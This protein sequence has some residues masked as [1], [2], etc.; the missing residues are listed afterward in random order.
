MTT[1]AAPTAVAELLRRQRAYWNTGATRS[2]DFRLA[3]LKALRT[4]IVQHQAEIIDAAKRDL[5]RPEFEGYIE[6]AVISEIDYVIKHL[7]RWAKPR[8][9]SLALS[10]RPG[11]AWVQPEP[12]GVVLVIGPWNYPFQLIISPLIGAIAAGNC[13]ILKPSELAPAT[14]A[15]LVQLIETTFD[16]A[17][18][19]LVEGGV[20]TAQALL[21]ERFDHIF[22]TGGERVGKIVMQAAAQHLTPVTLELGGKSPCIVDADVN[23]EV[24]ARRIVW[25]KCLNAGQTCVAPDYLLVDE[26]IK[27]ELVAALQQRIQACYGENP[28]QSPDYSRIVNDRQF[29]RLVGLLGQGTVLVGGDHNRDDRYIA[30]TLIDGIGWDDPIM[31]E[32]IFGP[33]LPIL[34]YRDLD[35]AIAAVNQRPKPL[36]LY[37]FSRDRQVQTQVIDRTTA[38]SMCLNDVV[39]QVA[40]WNLPFGGVGSSGMGSYHGQY[41]FDTFSNL[42][43]VLKKP[44]WLDVDWRYPP[45]QDKVK[46]FRKL[47]GLS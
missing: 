34:T 14:S 46:V 7:R 24:A 20:D 33:L 19:T 6:V 36:A 9:A 43:S 32:E 2:L 27:A 12:L 4:A 44:F 15:V 18:I 42:K 21:A 47:I 5:G 10:Q 31:Q 37:L 29:D 23:L 35:D 38:G 41:S 13:A 8:K 17:H 22:Y 11:S 28:A 1:L 16:P 39:V 40:V 30:P 26:R 3:Q 25:G 45:Y